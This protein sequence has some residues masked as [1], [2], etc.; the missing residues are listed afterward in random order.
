MSK[1]LAHSPR[2]PSSGLLSEMETVPVEIY[3]GGPH[4][5][6]GHLRDVLAAHITA[7]PSGGSIDWVTYYFRDL[8]LAEALIQ[9]RK[10]GVQVTLS[11]EGRPRIPHA[12]D[13]VIKMLS[14]P[15][16]LGDA[17]RI[18]A[19]PG[20]PSPATKSWKPQLH[21]KLYCFSHPEPVA[22]IG[23]FN[24]SGNMPEDDPE[25]I[26]EIGDQDRG[27]NALVGLNDPVLVEGLVN[28]ARQIHRSPPGLFYRFSTHASRIIHGA[29][30]TIHFWPRVS[31]HPVVQFLSRVNSGARIRVVASHIRTESA[32]DVMAGLARRG[33]TLEIFAESTHRRVTPKVERRLASAGIRFRRIR[34]PER[35]PMHLKFV[36]VEDGDHAWSIFGSFNWTKPSFWLNHEIAA[37]SSNPLIFQVLAH[38]WEVLENEKC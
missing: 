15:G 3:F 23:S 29:D 30:T 20:V 24:P 33:T 13:A 12:N 2:P 32:V 35:L 25:L 26:R 37:I 9:A 10:R 18:I 7:V 11:L 8:R 31:P 14:G 38:C 34:N 16:G 22:F 21:E 6:P 36:L 17:F 28:H 27:Y 19:I 1:S 4:Q 5:A